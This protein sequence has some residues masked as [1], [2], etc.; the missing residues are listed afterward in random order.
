MYLIGKMKFLTWKI[1]CC[2]FVNTRDA[3]I[4]LAKTIAGDMETFAYKMNEYASMIGMKNTKF[5]N[6]HGLE[7]KEGNGNISTAYDMALLTK[8]AMQNKTFQEIF[9]TKKY[10]AKSS[11]KTYV[12]T[13]KNK[14]LHQLEY[15]TGGKT[16]FTKKARRTLVTTAKKDNV[17]LVAV[18]LN[19]PNDFHDH[20]IM[21]ENIFD[22]YQAYLV[23]NKD[24]FQ[25][26]KDKIYQDNELYI[27]HNY[28]ATLQKDEVN[29]I[30]IKYQLYKDGNFNDG[31]VV[32]RSLVYLKDELLHEED[33]YLKKET[34]EKL[35][36]WEKVIGWFK[37]W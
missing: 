29:D 26:K 17:S 12:W 27:K 35:N 7:D 8:Y 33:I 3:A 25:V 24:N 1:F 5:I 23:L 16:G 37:K 28:Y 31:D 4:V 22:K 36:W 21:Y 14:L 2:F 32:G 13:N 30:E 19:A 15:I 9:S 10:K 18:T 34:D 6:A 11:Y 20:Q